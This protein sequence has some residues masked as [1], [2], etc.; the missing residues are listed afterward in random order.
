MRRGQHRDTKRDDGYRDQADW[1]QASERGAASRISS[2]SGS[3]VCICAHALF[4]FP[5]RC[6]RPPRRVMGKTSVEPLP[7]PLNVAPDQIGIWQ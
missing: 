3:S 6:A 1:E 5:L 2:A 4:T 7:P